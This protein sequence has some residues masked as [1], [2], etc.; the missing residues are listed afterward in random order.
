MVLIVLIREL[1]LPD[2]Q[3]LSPRQESRRA[4][5]FVHR[6]GSVDFSLFG[7]PKTAKRISVV[8]TPQWQA[9]QGLLGAAAAIQ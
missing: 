9:L 4:K 8:W 2:E 1:S 5:L 6:H 7:L 3:D